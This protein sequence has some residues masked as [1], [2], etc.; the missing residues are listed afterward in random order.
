MMGAVAVAA[1]AISLLMLAFAGARARAALLGKGGTGSDPRIEACTVT[2]SLP[3]SD[4][5]PGDGVA[6]TVYFNNASSGVVTTTFEVSGTPALLFV[7]DGAFGGP[8]GIYTSSLAQATFVVT[9]AVATGHG[10]QSGVAY[11]AMNGGFDQ[12]EIAV[13]YV[14]DVAAPVVVVTAPAKVPASP[15]TVSWE[16]VDPGPGSG[17][18][19]YTVMYREDGGAW[20]PW[21]A[22]TALTESAFLSATVDHTYTFSVTARDRVDNRGAEAASTQVEG[23][24]AYLPLVTS[25]WVWWYAFDVYEPND[26]IAQAYGPLA[27]TQVYT[28][29]IWDATDVDDYYHFTPTT[30]NT[31]WVTLTHV[32]A[33]ADYDLYVYYHDGAQFQEVAQSIRSGNQ[34]EDA[35]FTPVADTVYYTRIFPY[36][37]SSRQP[38]RLTVVYD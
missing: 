32:A 5:R 11:T 10:T 7:A 38:Y 25:D 21:L 18:V 4:T 1:A 37:G 22:S 31:V 24:R 12:A 15:F 8:L 26:K 29:Y 20:E 14:Q 23:Y 35:A 19:A 2:G 6:K 9:Y 33:G 17:V 28:A 36:S 16:A 13:S 30:T 27:S 3:I 34:D